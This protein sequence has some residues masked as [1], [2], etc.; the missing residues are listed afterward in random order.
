MSLICTPDACVPYLHNERWT[1]HL[2]QQKGWK[3][4]REWEAWSVDDQ[5][6]G[7]VTSYSG[8]T[9]PSI[10]ENFTFATVK[11]S[12]HMVPQFQPKRGFE[13]FKSFITNGPPLY[14]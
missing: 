13:L 5:V 9:A 4:T 3:P 1:Q 2:A 6:A 11:G 8:G 12:G 10:V 7:Y 14:N